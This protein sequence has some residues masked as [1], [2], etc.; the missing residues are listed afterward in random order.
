MLKFVVEAYLPPWETI[1]WSLFM[2]GELELAD[3]LGIKSIIDVT[4]R[5]SKPEETRLTWERAGNR[6]VDAK[7][8]FTQNEQS[9]GNWIGNLWLE[10]REDF[11]VGHEFVQ[12]RNDLENKAEIVK[13]RFEISNFVS[14][15]SREIQPNW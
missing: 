13:I 12:D 14:I 15:L 4:Q 1:G 11:L 2:F 10:W 6:I 9:M 3:W 7:V 5:K 8:H